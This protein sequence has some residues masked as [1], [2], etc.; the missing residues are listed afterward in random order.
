MLQE[1]TLTLTLS[2]GI[3]W[4]GHIFL[5]LTVTQQTTYKYYDIF[6][7]KYPKTNILF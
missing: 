3:S 2:A 1:R 5:I 7:S 4:K 6:Y